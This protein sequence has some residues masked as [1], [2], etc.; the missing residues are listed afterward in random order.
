MRLR[1]VWCA[2][3]DGVTLQV[4]EWIRAPGLGAVGLLLVALVF[5]CLDRSVE[6]AGSSTTVTVLG[7]LIT[8]PV[9]T[10]SPGD[11]V[12]FQAKGVTQGGDSVAVV[13]V[14]SARYGTIT[15]DGLYTAPASGQQ[16]VV[17]ARAA[18][19]AYQD[20]AL[21]NLVSLP[22]NSVT[23]SPSSA[24]LFTGEVAQLTAVVLNANGDTLNRTVTWTS[25]A[26]A[27][28]TVSSSGVV[29]ALTP[30]PAT[31][32]AGVS[33]K[34][35]TSA[36]T[37]VQAPPPGTWPDEPS[38]YTPIADEPWSVLS[39]LHWTLEFGTALITID[40]TAPESP[41]FVLQFT[42]PTG[43]AGGVAPG[44]MG[45]PL[46]G[47]H[48]LFVGMWWKPSNPWQGHLTGSNKIQYAFTDAHGSITM[49]MYGPIGGPFELRVYPQF[50]TSAGIWLTPN[51]AT[52]PVQL[53]VWH[54]IEWQLI[55]STDANTAN[56]ICRWWLDGT[57]VGDYEN[58]VFPSEGLTAYKI[59]PVWGGVQD[60]KTETDYYWIDHV[61]ISGN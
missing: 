3:R 57:L 17:I 53:G 46:S 6:V 24:Q 26:P 1:D 9:A 50:S 39:P 12:Q 13:V 47:Q 60:V 11:Q 34:Q 19:A 44:T 40:T 45:Y 20:S 42:Y 41:P 31:V 36:I 54:R 15:A 52:V 7:I 32:T 2:A 56:G 5:A 18:G 10:L 48:Q 16:D 22:V 8:P 4:P 30:G 43:F 28:A 51:V 61:H 37:V 23:I 35:G 27:V 33:G 58:L 29:S 21:I 49:V 59:A 25:S 14:W 38:S 55:Y